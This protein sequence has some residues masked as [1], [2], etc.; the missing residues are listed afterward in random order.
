MNVRPRWAGLALASLLVALPASV[1]SPAAADPLTYLHASVDF[2]NELAIL[3]KY[4]QGWLH[5][6]STKTP[7]CPPEETNASRAFCLVEYSYHHIRHLVR[8]TVTEQQDEHNGTTN[9]DTATIQFSRQ[10]RRKWRPAP[11]GCH[12]LQLHGRL[13]SN[14]RACDAQMADDLAP[15]I[16][17]HERLHVRAHGMDLAGFDPIVAYECT[18]RGRTITCANSL[19][20]AFRVTR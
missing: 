12:T 20:D 6:P 1:A 14:D 5:T 16:A 18:E 10:W 19:G 4:R 15:E 11:R 8:G 3:P 9:V 13:S 2:G 17:H 7:L